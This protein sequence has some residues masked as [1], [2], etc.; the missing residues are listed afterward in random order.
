MTS[1][2]PVEHGS[3]S[4]RAFLRAMREAP[5]FWFRLCAL[6]LFGVS[7]T[8]TNGVR[9]AVEALLLGGLVLVVIGYPLFRK[10]GRVP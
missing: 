8:V 2:Q 1:R 4:F 10:R 6:A 3:G 5:G 9:T 7:L